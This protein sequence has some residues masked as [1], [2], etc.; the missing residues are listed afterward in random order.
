MEILTVLKPLNDVCWQVQEKPALVP[1]H[2]RCLW[3][4]RPAIHILNFYNKVFT[5]MKAAVLCIAAVRPSLPHSSWGEDL[6]HPLR[7]HHHPSPPPTDVLWEFPNLNLPLPVLVGA[8]LVSL[9]PSAVWWA[10]RFTGQGRRRKYVRAVMRGPV[11]SP[12][13]Q[14]QVRKRH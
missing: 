9:R 5:W 4:T 7:W 13:L 10:C 8:T 2:L 11:P 14:Q 6:H 1:L 12:P 3:S